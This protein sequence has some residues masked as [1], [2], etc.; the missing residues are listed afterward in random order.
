MRV[1]NKDEFKQQKHTLTKELK[2]NV[3][4]YPTDSIYGVGCDATNK[5]LVQK[6]RELKNSTLQPFSIIAPSKEWVYEHCDVTPY[7]EEWVEKL[8]ERVD[9]DGEEKAISLVLKLKNKG[10]VAPNVM[11]GLDTI[12]VRIPNHWF[13]EFVTHMGVP[14]VTTSANP[15]GGDFMTSLEDL[16]PRMKAGAA[17][18]VYE[19][20]LKSNPS[21]LVFLDKGKVEFKKR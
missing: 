20:P 5:E 17:Y 9:I 14:L 18:C 21:T 4:I 3:F 12:S 11:Q 8:G 6:V 2:N 1:I 7:A 10:A 16:H 13:S 19:G 15:T